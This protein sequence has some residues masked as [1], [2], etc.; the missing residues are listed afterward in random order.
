MTGSRRKIKTKQFDFDERIVLVA[1]VDGL[2]FHDMSVHLYINGIDY[3][4]R[5]AL[6][7]EKVLEMEAF[8]QNKLNEEGAG[9]AEA[10][11]EFDFECDRDDKLME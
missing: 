5:S 8:F 9:R 2:E 1:E 11:A 3:D 6:P 7:T 4:I 10:K